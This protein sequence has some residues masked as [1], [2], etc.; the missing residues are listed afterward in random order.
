MGKARLYESLKHVCAG[1]V[2]RLR[3][4]LHHD[5]FGQFGYPYILIMLFCETMTQASPAQLQMSYL[6]YQTVKNCDQHVLEK[7]PHKDRIL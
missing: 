7:S 4:H 6:L 1:I 5:T 2:S 3:T